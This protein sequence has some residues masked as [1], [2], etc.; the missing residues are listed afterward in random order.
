VFAHEVRRTLTTY[1]FPLGRAAPA[2]TQTEEMKIPLPPEGQDPGA[3]IEG[4]LIGRIKHGLDDDNSNE[5]EHD[6]EPA[7]APRHASADG[8]PAE[9][10]HW[11]EGWYIWAS[12]NRWA[13]QEH[14]DKMTMPLEAQHDWECFKQRRNEDWAAENGE[15]LV[16]DATTAPFAPDPH[17][18]DAAEQ[19]LQDEL[20]TAHQ[21]GLP[22]PSSV[23]QSVLLALPP[24]SPFPALQAQLGSVLK[25]TEKVLELVQKS[26]RDGSQRELAGRLYGKAASSD[27][28]ILAKNAM[29][30]AW[31]YMWKEKKGGD[32]EDPN[33][34]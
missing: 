6:H 25:P 2:D 4:T 14:M 32:G 11:K 9:T 27:P 21:N 28:W 1:T 31:E 8:K 7:A 33:D 17:D 29:E 23:G 10:K 18:P 15:S 30:K 19:R 24:P 22:Y 26:L 20:W 5:P 16:H 34:G 3:V 13:A 12:K